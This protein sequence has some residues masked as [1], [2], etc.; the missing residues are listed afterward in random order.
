MKRFLARVC[1]C[2]CAV[3]LT[4]LGGCNF[5][6][7]K[8]ELGQLTNAA[9]TIET[10]KLNETSFMLKGA[11]GNIGV[12][13]GNEGVLI[14]D[15]QFASLSDKIF[16]AIGKLSDQPVRHVINSHWHHDHTG[17]NENFGKAGAIIVAHENLRTRLMSKQ[18]LK[19]WNLEFP[20]LPSVALPTMTYLQKLSLRAN[21][22][23][24]ELIHPHAA[25]TDGDSIVVFPEA[26]VIHMGDILTTARFP[27]IDRGAGG[28]VKGVI[29]AVEYALTV[30]N[31]ATKVIPGHGE[32]A[33]R[34]YLLTYLDMLNKSRAAIA[35]LIRAGKS[36]EEV[37]A[38]KPLAEL[39]DK[40]GK[41]A[42]T[43]DLFAGFV[44]DTESR[45]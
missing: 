45:L 25:H 23:H 35:P 20:A 26:N 28:S 2:I 13:V 31:D 30:S 42:V 27:Y 39:D 12:L 4:G 1:I 19:D 43:A 37:I 8:Y 3:F 24:A 9:A 32:L 33:D 7:F 40:W 41:G 15:T 34:K 21:G 18:T 14:V 11:G 36:R 38:A 22:Y 44:F 29:A 6:Q 10:V 17:G 16:A 5:A